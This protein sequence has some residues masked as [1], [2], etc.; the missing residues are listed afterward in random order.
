VLTLGALGGVYIGGG[1]VPRMVDYF[2][3]SP[4]H[5]S[6]LDKGRYRDYLAPVPIH[7]ITAPHP[8]FRGLAHAFDAPGPRLESLA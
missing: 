6:Y 2:L 8:A 7:I 5:D 4:F 1:I 3:R